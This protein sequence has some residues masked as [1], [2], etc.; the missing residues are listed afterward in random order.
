MPQSLDPVNMWP[1]TA[2][3]TWQMYFRIGSALDTLIAMGRERAPAGGRDVAE[4]MAGRKV[5]EGLDPA[6]LEALCKA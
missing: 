4:R 2:R 5:R 6:R 3:E 1:S